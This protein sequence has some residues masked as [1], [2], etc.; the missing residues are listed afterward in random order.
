MRTRFEGKATSGS[1][2]IAEEPATLAAAANSRP[3]LGVIGH[4]LP[5][6]IV[7]EFARF[8]GRSDRREGDRLL[9]QM[10]V[11]PK[12]LIIRNFWG[13]GDSGGESQGG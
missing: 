11:A 10:P 9:Y 13:T 8:A 12:Y 6:D 1:F 2:A 4:R 5:D 7:S 3:R